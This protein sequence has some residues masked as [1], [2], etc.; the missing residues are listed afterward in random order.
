M[1]IGQGNFWR[2]RIRV[3]AMVSQVL[4]YIIYNIINVLLIGLEIDGFIYH[5]DDPQQGLGN[6]SIPASSVCNI[7]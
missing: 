7:G 6:A 5:F 2:T 3:Y 1:A 4:K